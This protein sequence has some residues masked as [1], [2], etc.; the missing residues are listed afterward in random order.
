MHTSQVMGVSAEATEAMNDR[1]RQSR[2][3]EIANKIAM[4]KLTRAIS[5]VPGGARARRIAA[6]LDPRLADAQAEAVQARHEAVRAERKGWRKM[7]IASRM[8]S[9]GRAGPA[10]LF[11]GGTS[12]PAV[13]L[14]VAK[15]HEAAA[16]IERAEV[17]LS[18]I[19]I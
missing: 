10:G 11:G 17:E 15:E 4:R 1:W 6:A 19:H 9:L 12:K 5:S 14:K 16:A 7:G 13:A 18:L 3:D 2:L 8:G